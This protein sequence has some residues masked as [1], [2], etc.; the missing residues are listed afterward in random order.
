MAFPWAARKVN[1]FSRTLTSVVHS[2][3][4]SVDSH[5]SAA[6]QLPPVRFSDSARNVELSSYL[7]ARAVKKLSRSK[8][9]IYDSS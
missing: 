9:G 1:L 7:L 4:D 5:F 2:S 3:W 8:D 6:R